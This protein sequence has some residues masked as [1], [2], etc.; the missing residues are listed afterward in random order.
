MKFLKISDLMNAFGQP[1]YKGL[2]IS[3][4]VPGSPRYPIDFS[5]CILATEEDF[6]HHED[7]LEL[8]ESEYVVLK[9]Q[10]E[11]E[12]KN[13]A[14]SLENRL[15]AMEEEK[16]LMQAALDELILGGTL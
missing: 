7:I 10:I 3:K 5:F 8:S 9:S 1:S 14:D 4:F 15:K 6:E 12:H 2:D 16:A 13:A 11:D